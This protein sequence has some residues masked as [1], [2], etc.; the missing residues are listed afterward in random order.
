VG[1]SV[2]SERARRSIYQ[3]RRRTGEATWRKTSKIGSEMKYRRQKVRMAATGRKEEM[4]GVS[5]HVR[6]EGRS[7]EAS[8]ME[9][10]VA[11]GEARGAQN[12]MT[13]CAALK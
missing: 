7:G 9:A 12:G 13:S 8:S 6:K 4:E 10:T 3:I 1:I 11:D 2:S 5:I